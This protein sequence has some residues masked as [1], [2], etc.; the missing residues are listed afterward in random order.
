MTI[1]Q[2]ISK[3]L[4]EDGGNWET[5]EGVEFATLV[6]AADYRYVKGDTTVYVFEDGSMIVASSF[7]DILTVANLDGEDAWIDS[8]G[9]VWATLEDDGLPSD[10]WQCRH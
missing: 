1:A 2:D 7:W 6:E 4:G 3:A 8:N 10:T 5:A 9:E